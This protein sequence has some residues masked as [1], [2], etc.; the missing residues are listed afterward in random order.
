MNIKTQPLYFCC[1]KFFSTFHLNFFIYIDELEKE[2]A[3]VE[4]SEEEQELNKQGEEE[5]NKQEEEELNKQEEEEFIRRVSIE[6][7]ASELD[8]MMI[9]DINKD[10]GYLCSCAKRF[11]SFLSSKF[12]KSE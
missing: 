12:N 7:E 5:L 6:N 3:I 8:D 4:K 1:L 9:D 2:N 11:S 10:L